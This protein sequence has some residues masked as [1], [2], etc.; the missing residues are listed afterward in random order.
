MPLKIIKGYQ[1]LVA[2]AEK[3]IETISVQ[4]ALALHGNKDVV[5]VDL[6]DVRELW[7]EG[8]IPET[9]HRPRGNEPS[10]SNCLLLPGGK[11]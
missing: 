9:F 2:Q 8:F 10:Q 3:E 5:F 11:R 7:R 1:R 6:R 4:E